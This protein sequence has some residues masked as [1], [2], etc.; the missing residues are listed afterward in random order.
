MGR[1]L[2]L[3]ATALLPGAAVAAPALERIDPDTIVRVDASSTS[4]ATEKGR[5]IFDRGH[6]IDGRDWSPWGSRRDDARGAWIQLTFD[7]VRYVSK[8]EFVP[9]NERD[10]T[11]YDSCGRPARLRVEMG[12]EQRVFD[13]RDRRFHQEV[14]LSPPPGGRTLRLV[15]EDVHGRG[16]TGGVCLSELGLH[17]PGDVL[18]ARP[19]LAERIRVAIDLLT[20]DG[21]A[22]RGRR[23][24]AAVGPP[25]VPALLAALDDGNPNLAARA[26][27]ALGEIGDPRAVPALARLAEHTDRDLRESALWALGALRS[28]EHYDRIKA[29]FDGSHGQRRDRAF[30][31]LARLGDPRALDVIVAELLNG[32]A[33]RR[34]SAER[35]LG[36]FGND[37]VEALRPLLASEIPLER[38]AALRALGGVDHPEAREHLLGGLL[39]PQSD[40]RAAAVLGL[41]RRGDQAARRHVLDRWQSRYQQE[42]QAVAVALG[43]FADP[44]DLEIVELLTTDAS[45]SVRV[46]ATRSL[47]RFGR[48]ADPLL[49]RLA[50]DGPDGA[51]ARAAAETLLDGDPPAERAV[52]LLGSR[53]VEVRRV[54][55]DVLA[56]TGTAGRRAL[57]R[58]VVGADDRVRTGAVEELR[59]AGE[60]VMPALLEAASTAPAAAQPDVLALIAHFGDP[61]GV[62]YAAR[63]A[64]EGADLTVRRAAIQALG[65]CGDRRATPALLDAL[66]DPA[67]E[68]RRAA[69]KVLGD[70]RVRSAASRLVALLKDEDPALRRAA[71]VA[72]GQLRDRRALEPLVDQYKA[73]RHDI[74]KAALRE[75][76]VVAIGRIGGRESLPVLIEAMSDDDVDVRLAAEQALR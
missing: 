23:A 32:S 29:W 52:K 25:A 57:V 39:A 73:H 46:A 53:H 2:L 11:A 63:L 58:A 35:F 49:E 59:R 17:A 36:R 10:R 34:E 71:V 27:A 15:F 67:V 68:V 7:R 74:E 26:A 9:G 69:V 8:I 76:L 41:A 19:D 61:R 28:T 40:I 12:A 55:G 6:L 13:L 5:S 37:A 20:D 66:D 22:E 43:A 42:R 30:D 64:R 62:P 1:T 56:G 47:G 45:M 4:E 16:V 60:M 72:L 14:T 51:T 70:L 31:A 33:A 18:G 48:A 24:L 44:R 65:R 3:A 75:D 38:A 21:R 54:A 50:L